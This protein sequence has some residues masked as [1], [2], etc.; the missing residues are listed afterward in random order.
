MALR[1]PSPIAT[2]PGSAP[3]PHRQRENITQ[4]L[5]ISVVCHEGHSHDV[6]IVDYIKVDQ[7]RDEQN[8]L[9]VLNQE[10]SNEANHI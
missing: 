8:P 2:N 6:E 9:L 4:H 1:P 10:A 3:G 7:A 5:Q